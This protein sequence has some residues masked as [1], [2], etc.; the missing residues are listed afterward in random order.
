[1][2]RRS[3]PPSHRVEQPRPRPAAPPPPRPAP[4]PPPRPAP[5]PA[6]VAHRPAAP[7]RSQERGRP[8]AGRRPTGR[9]GARPGGAPGH[10]PT[11][12]PTHRPEGH[13][14]GGGALTHKPTHP[15]VHRPTGHAAGGPPPPDLTGGT[16]TGTDYQ[17]EIEALR[18]EVGNLAFGATWQ[19]ANPP[20]ISGRFGIALQGVETGS[21]LRLAG[22]TLA[23]GMGRAAGTV[24]KIPV[25]VKNHRTPNFRR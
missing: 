24:A 14:A 15:P 6:P 4:P 16:L 7:P 23:D 25:L 9:A 13:Q 3:G 20:K 18:Q 22:R 2:A 5:R 8:P 1:M 12:A 21:S 17:K 19:S 11:H 10:K